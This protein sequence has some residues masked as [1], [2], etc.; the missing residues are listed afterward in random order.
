MERAKFLEQQ[1]NLEK[2]V[3]K[4]EFINIEKKFDLTNK[5]FHD[6]VKKLKIEIDTNKVANDKFNEDL[7]MRIEKFGIS[8]EK[9]T[10]QIHNTIVELN[11]K[12]TEF[13]AN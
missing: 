9:N 12:L 13:S 10:Y 2:S 1:I 4:S 8:L 5:R 6:T 3:T 11:K 7:S